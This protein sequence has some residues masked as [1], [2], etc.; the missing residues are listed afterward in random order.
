M[1]KILIFIFSCCLL[2]NFSC[3]AAGQ[4]PKT[5]KVYK[6]ENGKKILDKSA[7]Y[8][9]NG[10]KTEEINYKAGEKKESVTYSYNASGKCVEEKHFDASG[11]LEKTVKI[12]YNEN[13]K[14]KSEKSY[15][16]NGKLKNEHVYEYSY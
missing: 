9:A 1:K 10:N 5:L 16:F 13:G 8:D 2:G 6:V 14:K 12:E 15:L 11:K 3:F 4:K 7:S